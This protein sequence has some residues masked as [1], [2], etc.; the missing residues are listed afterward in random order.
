MDPIRF[1]S[2]IAGA[3]AALAH[4]NIIL[5]SGSGSKTDARA[6]NTVSPTTGKMQ[7]S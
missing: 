4:G 5:K 1:A 7:R 3:H 6:S 2:A